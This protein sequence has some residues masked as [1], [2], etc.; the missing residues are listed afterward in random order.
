MGKRSFPCCRSRRLR[1]IRRANRRVAFFIGRIQAL[2]RRFQRRQNRQFSENG[3]AAQLFGGAPEQDVLPRLN[4]DVGAVVRHLRVR[5]RV[6][7]L[8]S[9]GTDRFPMLYMGPPHPPKRGGRP[10]LLRTCRD[11]CTTREDLPYAWGGADASCGVSS[12]AVRLH[13]LRPRTPAGIPGT[14]KLSSAAGIHEIMMGSS[15]DI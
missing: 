3:H 11:P 15:I 1:L 2:R 14:L 10:P 5:P 9:R 4:R 12:L 7:V 6:G 13:H 8:Y